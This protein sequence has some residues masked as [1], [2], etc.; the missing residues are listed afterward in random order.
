MIIKVCG[1]REPDNIRAVEALGVDWM[2]FVF[3]HKSARYAGPRPEYLPRQAKRI[4][5]FVNENRETIIQRLQLYRLDGVQLHGSE[6]PRIVENLKLKLPDT[7][8]IKA[9]PVSDAFDIA[10]T[11]AY[12]GLCDYFLFDAKCEGHGGSGTR[13]DW[14][15]LTH[16]KGST[17]FLLSG[18]IGPDALP[19]LQGLGLPQWA[20]VD[21]NSRFESAPGLKDPA[22]LEPFIQSVRQMRNDSH[23]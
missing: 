19:A 14:E 21:L 12:D 11:E 3:Y 16:Y 2:G 1:M 18:G 9:F 10:A 23:E 8:V 6:S 7:I 22:L 20:G 4:G 13:F 5:V 17:P 15:L